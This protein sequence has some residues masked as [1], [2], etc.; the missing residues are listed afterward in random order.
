MKQ[1][2]SYCETVPFTHYSAL[3]N[4]R[5]LREQAFSSLRKLISTLKGAPPEFIVA[6]FRYA[7]GNNYASCHI[8]NLDTLLIS[9]PK[10]APETKV[11]VIFHKG[12]QAYVERLQSSYAI[13]GVVEYSPSVS[14]LDGLMTQATE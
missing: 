4:Q 1:I 5:G 14:A 8:G 11:I 2:Y 9:I 12:E 7:W 13:H 3:F 6:E 10:Y